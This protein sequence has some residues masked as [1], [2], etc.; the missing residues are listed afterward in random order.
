MRMQID[1]SRSYDQSSR[2]DN[3]SIRSGKSPSTYGLNAI[4]TNRYIT[5]DSG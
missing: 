1:K 3:N 5:N 2:I 4:L